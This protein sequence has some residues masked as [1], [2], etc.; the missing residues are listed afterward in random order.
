MSHSRE[1]TWPHADTWLAGGGWKDAAAGLTV[2]GA[3][4]PRDSKTPGNCDLAPAAIRQ[5]LHRFSTYDLGTG[6]DL[7]HLRVKDAGD[8]N[9]AGMNPE[10]AFQPIRDAVAAGLK[11][12]N[13]VVLLG[14]DSSITLPGVHGLGVRLDH[15]GLVT[16]DGHFGLH[17]LEAGLT[18]ANP[19]RA[20]LR[21]GLQGDHIYQIGLQRFANSEPYAGV[22]RDAGIHVMTADYVM[23]HGITKVVQQALGHLHMHVEHIY[24]DLDLDVLDRIHAPATP[25]A[26]PG[27][28]TPHQIRRVA[29]LC[30]MHP[31]VRVLDLVEIDPTQDVADITVLTAT[32]CLLEFAS[33][34]L[35]RPHHA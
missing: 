17:G 31:K 28:L 27:G 34:V 4:V 5:A 33:G 29:H 32:A 19:V 11:G 6:R 18:S 8:L 35:G 16:F 22:A 23:D 20:L 15:C 2:L 3:P 24:V 14:G 12:G 7:R 10:Q 1:S 13:A 9:L 26:Q 30:G 21:D 25:D